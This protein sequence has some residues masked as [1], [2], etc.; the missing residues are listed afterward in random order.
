MPINSQAYAVSP[1]SV[2]AQGIIRVVAADD[3]ALAEYFEFV[4]G[5][6]YTAL[7]PKVGDFR[8]QDVD[9]I[10]E[11]DYLQFSVDDAAGFANIFL[12][13]ANY[14]QFTNVAAVYSLQVANACAGLFS[15]GVRS[16]Q[17]AN[18]TNAI[19]VIAGNTDVSIGSLIVHWYTQAGEPALATNEIATWIDTGSGKYYIGCNSNGAGVK[20]VEIT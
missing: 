8:V 10:N 3:A 4:L 19:Q 5:A 2:P 16:V 6:T 20:S 11:S 14:F 9:D 12:P 13:A 18:G 1:L 17:V 7:K 15:D